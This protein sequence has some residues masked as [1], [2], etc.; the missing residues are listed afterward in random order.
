[1]IDLNQ[2]TPQEIIFRDP[3]K[4]NKGIF[5][6]HKSYFV[7]EG[8][9]FPRAGRC[10]NFTYTGVS[11]TYGT[12]YQ[13]ESVT[14]GNKNLSFSVQDPEIENGMVWTQFLEVPGKFCLTYTE[15]V[16]AGNK[17][18]TE[19]KDFEDGMNPAALWYGK[20]LIE[21]FKIMREWSL[22]V[23]DPF[24]LDHPM[25]IYSK[26]VFDTLQ[27]PS[28]IMEEIDV[29]PDMHLFRFLKGDDNHRER[30]EDFPKMSTEM[31]HWFLKKMEEY[32]KTT[33]REKLKNLVI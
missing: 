19:A 33:T 22:M 26:M 15:P 9:N 3:N 5:I 2:I 10:D 17:S 8:F 6:L 21:L 27:P 24:N 30:Q 11:P 32:P 7:I 23:E 1:M 12:E 13:G 25:A 20:S 31:M 18:K 28:D 14:I 4:S 29:L 16:I